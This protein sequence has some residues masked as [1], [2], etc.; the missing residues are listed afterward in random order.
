MDPIL[1]LFILISVTLSA[2]LLSVKSWLRKDLALV[3]SFI[4]RIYLIVAIIFSMSLGGL[5]QNYLHFGILIVF[6]GDAISSAF[7]LLGKRLK[8]EQ[9]VLQV[10]ATL[11]GLDEKYS[12]LI[13]TV[14]VGIYTINESGRFEFVNKAFAEIFEMPVE[15][16]LGK[17]IYEFLPKDLI[18]SRKKEVISRL[19]IPD[20]EVSYQTPV[21]TGRGNIIE[22]SVHAK[23]TSNGHRTITGSILKVK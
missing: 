10:L 1:E 2:I 12:F 13:N 4:P 22:V 17:T 19:R 6:L 14:P 15:E 3:A 7:I 23:T 11:Q 9:Y 8:L 5:H 18:E 21:I 16:M 20:K